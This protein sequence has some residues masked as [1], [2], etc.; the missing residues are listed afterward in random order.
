M[1][2]GRG[3]RRADDRD[4]R[5]GCRL[6]EEPRADAD[7][8]ADDQRE[9]A[10]RGE[11]GS[12]HA[13]SGW[14]GVGRCR[15]VIGVPRR[16]GPRTAIRSAG[17]T[18]AAGRRAAEPRR[19]AAA[20]AAARSGRPAMGA[21]AACGRLAGT[22]RA[23]ARGPRMSDE[24][25]ARTKRSR[26]AADPEPRR[27]AA[28]PEPSSPTP[29]PSPEPA[30]E[31]R[32]GPAVGAGPR[33][34]RD[35]PRLEAPRR[36]GHEPA[37]PAPGAPRRSPRRPSRRRRPDVAPARRARQHRR[38]DRGLRRGPHGRHRRA[39]R[40]G[41][42]RPVGRRRRG[43]RPSSVGVEFGSVGA[44][45]AGE[46]RVTQG[47]AGSVIAREAIHR[48][49]DRPDRDR[50]AGDDHAAV[51]RARADRR[52]GRG[53]GPAAARLARARW[54]PAL[55]FGLVS[56]PWR[57]CSASGADAGAGGRPTRS[58]GRRASGRPGLRDL[59]RREDARGGCCG[60]PLR[61]PLL[62]DGDHAPSGS[63]RGRSWPFSISIARLQYSVTQFMSWVT[64]TIAF[65]SCTSSPTRCLDFSRNAA[66]PVDRTSSSSR[67]SGSTDGRDREARAAPACPRSRS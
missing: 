10:E 32:R 47:F 61:G 45:L 55:A 27:R 22:R 43:A 37:T 59:R 41:R 36:G 24:T 11:D 4:G 12:A 31:R 51:G 63:P 19:S 2:A 16:P 14:S 52:E 25:P 17:H 29:A 40:A 38:G 35:A 65:A 39:G 20:V 49:G 64:S 67:M 50:A 53:R 60:A 6:G 62:V 18:P 3:G 66:S 54:P 9:D 28:D 7:A 33:S 15:G 13:G 44:A 21:A 26:A 56:A 8:D 5:G 1:G 42:L 58:A 30:A 23:A 57:R 34:A 46:L 48:A